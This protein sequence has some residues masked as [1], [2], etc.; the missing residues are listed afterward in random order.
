MRKQLVLE[1]SG[2]GSRVPKYQHLFCNTEFG[3]LKFSPQQ[4]AHR[5]R[6]AAARP[7]D[8]GRTA[9]PRGAAGAACMT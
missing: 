9:H 6:T 4:T 5:L 1:R 3:T 8:A 7:A 2:F